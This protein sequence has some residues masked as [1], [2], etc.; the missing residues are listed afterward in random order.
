MSEFRR[1]SICDGVNFASITDD[2]FK[3][4][5]LS[6]TLITPLSRE[7]AAANALLSCVL[8]RSCKKYPDFTALNR[9]LDSLYGAALYPSIR[10]LGDYQALTLSVTGLD[11]RYALD[12]EDV[13]SELARLLCSII[14]DPNVT[15]GKFS[16]DDVE[17]ER[18]ELIE[19]IDADYNDKRTYAVK[20]CIEN[21]CRDEI[22]SVGRIGSREDVEKVSDEDIYG[23][24]KKLLSGARVELT[25]LGNTPPE[26]AY[27]SFCGYFENKPRKFSYVPPEPV[28]PGDL[29]RV[30]ET[31]EVVQSKLV[32]GLRCAVP[33]KSEDM[34]ALSLMSAVLGGTP[35]SKLFLNV[36]EK[37]SLC[38]YCVS[39]VDG[40]KGIMLIDSGVETDNIEK[41]EKAV[42]EQIERLQNGELTEDE[43][44]GAKL[45]LKNV[46]MSSLD[47]LAAQQSFYI[48]SVLQK[49]I[50][51]P[52]QAA[53]MVDLVDRNRVIELARS[54]QPDTVYSLVG[55]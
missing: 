8:T 38:Y 41:T 42:M 50:M 55:N 53:K 46:Y 32:M 52:E 22:Y 47:S 37:Q 23:A 34:I 33:E 2:R 54:L 51:T 27:E 36:R 18:R 14:F 11:D 21:M 1:R 4:G 49:E 15:D 39:R 20:R 45:A 31:D 35:T 40:Y 3:L 16:E 30:V 28:V 13:S 43:F 12:G 19:G 9:K 25:M 5:R 24:W 6:A 48:G 29:R 10:Q 17:Q 26:K 44:E 7:R